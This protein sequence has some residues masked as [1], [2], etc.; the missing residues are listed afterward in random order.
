[1]KLR[2]GS[3]GETR[4]P[5]VGG[6]F[7]VVVHHTLAKTLF[8]VD[9]LVGFVFA[10]A[11]VQPSKC[12]A[13]VKP[14]S[15]KKKLKDKGF[16]RTVSRE[17]LALGI[18]EIGISAEEHIANVIAAL[19]EAAPSLGACRRL[20]ANHETRSFHLQLPHSVYRPQRPR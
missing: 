5:K 14:S 1:V 15:V 6:R 10:C 13:D 17:D 12:V 8:A 2:R 18:S 3:Q 19:T 11:Y 9:E 7:A 20:S 4:P 16:A